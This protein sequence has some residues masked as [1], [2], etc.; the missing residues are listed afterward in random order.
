M[1]SALRYQS[2]IDL[3]SSGTSLKSGTKSSYWVTQVRI[4]DAWNQGLRG[5]NSE[6]Y[7]SSHGNYFSKTYLCVKVLWQTIRWMCALKQDS[8]FS[9]FCCWQSMDQSGRVC[10][11]LTIKIPVY[12]CSKQIG[13][14][15]D[16]S[17][18]LIWGHWLF[19]FS[20]LSSPDSLPSPPLSFSSLG[21]RHVDRRTEYI[22][23]EEW[24][25]W[26]EHCEAGGPRG[27]EARRQGTT[28]VVARYKVFVLASKEEMSDPRSGGLIKAKKRGSEGGG[29]GFRC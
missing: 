26:W 25:G 9:V 11:Y 1:K 16:S 13:A 19:T 5:G 7:S 14:I 21:D 10:S 2:L 6:R 18:R 8:S 4:D 23:T 28:T 15:S 24:G 17:D 22:R 3:W 12:L 27:Q 20:C 29:G